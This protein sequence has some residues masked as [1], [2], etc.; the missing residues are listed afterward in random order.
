MNV[1]SHTYM[2]WK[3][4]ALRY[5]RVNATFYETINPLRT[6]KAVSGYNALE[7]RAGGFKVDKKP[8]SGT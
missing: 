6:V 1:D 8:E 7:T 2:H 3:A 5:R 4:F